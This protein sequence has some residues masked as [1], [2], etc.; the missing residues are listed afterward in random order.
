[1]SNPL[2]VALLGAGG[3]TRSHL[4]A[5]LEHSYR[6][7]LVAICDMDEPRAVALAEEAGI[8]TIYTDLDTMLR[9]ADIDA[10]DNCTFHPAHAPLSITAMEAGKHVLVE[11]PM[12]MSV[13]ECEDMIAVADKTGRT[14]MI[15]QD[16]RYSPEAVC[17][18]R[19]I[20]DGKLGDI[21]AGRTHLMQ[22]FGVGHDRYADAKQGG[23]ILM[24]VQIHHIDLL[25]YYMGN[26][27]R[28]TAVC[29]SITDTMANDAED[30]VT[31]I[32]EF[33]SGAVGSVFA[34]P[35]D[36]PKDIVDG[37]RTRSD[38]EYVV[39]G[40]AGTIHSTPQ[41]DRNMAHFGEVLFAPLTGESAGEFTPVDTS[42]AGTPSLKPFVNQILHFEECIRTGAEPVSSG[43]DNIDTMKIIFAI[44][45]SS[46]TGKA[47]E[48]ID[49]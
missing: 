17:V 34:F 39:H 38:R 44:W 48:L 1:M 6:V 45:E 14:L 36:T 15:A 37:K 43:R 33:E 23:G 35:G 16:L 7:E 29:K 5:Y 2:K 47:V 24:S 8:D 21:H 18:K 10:I 22:K 40:S 31:A 32:L 28:V 30:L 13:Q 11:K 9:E 3:I 19:L 4:P 27:K 46:K 41:T 49:L 12:A 26:V 42:D 20:D 25:R